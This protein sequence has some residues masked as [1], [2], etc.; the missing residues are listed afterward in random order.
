M[1]SPEHDQIVEL[2]VA[3]RA[4][5]GAGGAELSLDERRAGY[6]AVMELFPLPDGLVVEEVDAGGVPADR[7]SFAGADDDSGPVVLYLH[8]GGYCIG[9]PRTHRDLASRIAEAAGGSAIV[10]AY[11]LAPE[12]PFPAAVD[13][14][15]AAYRWLVTEVG[16]ER[17]VLAGDSAGGGLAL[18]L[19]VAARD[20]RL[21]LPAGIACFS[22]WTDLDLAGESM[23]GASDPILT[24]TEVAAMRDAYLAGAD[25][26]AP[27][28]SPL[29][30]DLRGLPPVLV[31]V[32]T[33]ELVLD[34]SRR[35][36]D[37]LPDA[38][39][40]EWPDLVHVFPHV[41][42]HAPESVAAVHAIGHF[43]QTVARCSAGRGLLV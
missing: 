24:R 14:S 7:L 19:A 8:G 29:Y 43:A 2:L 23:S 33:A 9:S 25:R 11:R 4:A 32:G 3:Q 6:E 22:P 35:I 5:E 1:P 21:P 15:L 40:V 31:H 16:A 38:E 34:D 39:L 37:A 13:D 42:P 12:H 27:L 17:I 41:A 30:A 26:R 20:A 10:P 18:C 36:V 28:A